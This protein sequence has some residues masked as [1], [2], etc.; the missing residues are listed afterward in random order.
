MSDLL[1]DYDFSLPESLIAS[2]PL[3]ERDASRML[4]LDRDSGAITHARVRDLRSFLDDGDLVILN[5]SRVMRARIPL[6]AG[7]EILLIEPIGPCLWKCMVRP[8]RKFQEGACVKIAGGHCEVRKILDDG[9][10]AIAF[11]HEPDLGAVGKMPIPPYLGREADEEDDVRYQTVFA[12]EEGSVAAPTAGLH[13]T[14]ELLAAIPHAFLTLHVGVGTFRPVTTENVAD[15]KMHEE[16]FEL[17]EKTASAAN[18][19]SR[20]VAVGTTVVRV[21][22]SRPPGPLL[23]GA[24]T[25]DIFIRPPHQFQRVGAVLTN[26]HLPRSTLLMLVSAFAGRELMLETYRKAVEKG[27]RFFSYG[28]CMFIR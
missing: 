15:H 3:P 7:G 8:G 12:R 13:F 21:L 19:A 26:F 14:P 25:T 20:I 6:P 2:R 18:S 10:R 5:D 27:Y 23:P 11:D 22:E 16:R 17:S 28:D 4:V 24:G 9:L 1:S